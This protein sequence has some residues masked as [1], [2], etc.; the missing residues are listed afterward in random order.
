MPSVTKTSG[1]VSRATSFE[2]PLFLSA[3]PAPAERTSDQR[4]KGTPRTQPYSSF[5]RPS[6][7]SSA[8]P[9]VGGI[10]NKANQ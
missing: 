2:C 6:A 5:G 8:S 9:R 1:G 7:E 10:K 4:S 3:L